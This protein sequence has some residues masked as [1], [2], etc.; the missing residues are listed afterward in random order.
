MQTTYHIDN[1][2]LPYET[3]RDLWQT[4]FGLQ[5]VDGLVPSS[6][7]VELAEK[8]ARGEYSYLEVSNEITHYHETVDASTKEADLV[9]LRIVELLSRN[10][11][12]FSPATLLSIHK[13]LFIGVFDQLIPVG[14]YRKTNITKDEPVLAGDTVVYSDYT[15]IQATLDY[16]FQQEKQFSYQGLNKEEMISHIQNFI[17]GIWQI[18]PFREGNTR[19]VTVFLI[20]YLREFGF[21]IDSQPFQDHARYFR[22]ALVLDNAKML[23][24]N[25]KY[26]N[27][28]FENLLLDKKHALSSD[29]MYRELGLS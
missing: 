25:S 11:F 13:E 2:N 7:M 24:K 6:Y 23:S 4:G 9:A 22:D 8:Q 3:K 17:S 5:K 27:L 26:L 29:E 1:P 28:F 16:D 20:K 18:H 10:G 14:K 19:T 15:M 21:T 12:T